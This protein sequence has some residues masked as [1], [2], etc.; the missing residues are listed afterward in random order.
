M[1]QF[2]TYMSKSYNYR[3][4]SLH[5]KADSKEGIIE[6]YLSSF[7]NTDSSGDI[8]MQGAFSKSI[9][10]RGPKSAKPRIKYLLN[11][12][13]SSP[14]GTFTELSEDSYGLKYV[15]TVGD[16]SLAQDYIKMVEGGAITEHS[17]GYQVMKW[18]R[19]ANNDTIKLNEVKLWEGSGLTGWGVNE[20]TPIT[21]LKSAEQYKNRVKALEHFIRHTDATDECIEGLMIEIK[22]LHQLLIDIATVPAPATQPEE[23]KSIDWSNILKHI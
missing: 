11:H 5:V 17:I 9:M 10:E 12:D 14:V 3:N 2:Y 21:S 1:L 19:D 16:W 8:M 4:I 6:G 15:A 7:G 13:V 18:E 20:N 22:Q 23:K